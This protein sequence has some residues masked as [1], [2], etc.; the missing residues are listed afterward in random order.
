MLASDFFARYEVYCPQTLAMADDPVG[1][2]IGTL[3][4]DIQKVM[5]TLDIREQTVQEAIDQKVDVILAKHPVIFRPLDNLTDQ[6]TQQKIILD[7]ARAGIAVY[8][9]H[10]NI[11]IV[12]N[13]LNDWFCELLDITETES[14]TDF[15]LG[16]VGNIQPQS[17]GDFAE[18]VKSLFELSGVTI[19][20]Y[21]PSL[22]QEIK[23]VAIWWWQ[24]WQILSRRHRQTSRCLC[25]RR[26]LLS[27]RP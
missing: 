7:L 19:V 5:V 10:T 2:Q 22:S 18:K 20:S 24:W 1:L 3:N 14:L 25:D 13:G 17:L 27:H 11:D 21:D 4:K 15:G 26:H 23:R 16:R 8:T 6:D 9:S 12:E